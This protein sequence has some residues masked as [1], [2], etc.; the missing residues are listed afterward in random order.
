MLELPSIHLVCF[1]RREIYYN[2][3]Y[4]IYDK[5][6]HSMIPCGISINT[7]KD[8]IGIKNDIAQIK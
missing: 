1:V 8:V 3:L 5:I 6:N 7:V 2:D 4:I